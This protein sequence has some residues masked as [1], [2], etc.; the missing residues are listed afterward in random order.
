MLSL[1]KFIVLS[2]FSHGDETFVVERVLAG[3]GFSVS[4]I[5]VLNFNGVSGNGRS[6]VSYGVPCDF[7]V[8]VDDLGRADGLSGNGS[9]ANFTRR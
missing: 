4:A 5:F 7:H 6:V 8:A 1:F 3:S 9:V 2:E